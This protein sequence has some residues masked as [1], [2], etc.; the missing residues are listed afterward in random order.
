MAKRKISSLDKLGY[1]LLVI[2]TLG[3]AWGLK[4]VIVKALNDFEKGE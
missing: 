3:S 2:G 4:C 1:Y